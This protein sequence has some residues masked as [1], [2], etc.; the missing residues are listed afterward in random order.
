MNYLKQI[1]R[2][3]PLFKF[4]YKKIEASGDLSPTLV[5]A[6]FQNHNDFNFE[7]TDE[8]LWVAIFLITLEESIES[9]VDRYYKN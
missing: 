1:K 8:R 3:N 2:I 9:K 4:V 7:N 6:M 5:S